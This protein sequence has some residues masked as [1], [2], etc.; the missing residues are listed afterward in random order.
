MNG[1]LNYFPTVVD[2]C[3]NTAQHGNDMGADSLLQNNVEGKTSCENDEAT[4]MDV[5]CETDGESCPP[6]S[7]V[8]ST[9]VVQ[10]DPCSSNE[11]TPVKGSPARE[12]LSKL[13]L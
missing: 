3:S 2:N 9:T 12:F 4:G 6:N 11:S 8:G 7:N 5:E 10:S 13:V 1:E